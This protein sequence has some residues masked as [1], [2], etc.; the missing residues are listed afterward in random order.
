MPAGRGCSVM[1]LVPLRLSHL[2]ENSPRSF[3]G[4]A[5]RR[6][7][8]PEPQRTI[9][10]WLLD[11]GFAPSARPGMTMESFY[12]LLAERRS[13]HVSLYPDG[14]RRCI[15][16][17]WQYMRAGGDTYGMA[18]SSQTAQLT[19]AGPFGATWPV[20]YMPFLRVAAVIFAAVVFVVDTFFAIDIAIAVLYV[21]VVILSI[22][23][24]DRRGFMAVSAGCIGL[25][26]LAF[27][28][29]APR[30]AALQFRRALCCQPSG[31]CDHHLPVRLDPVVNRGGP[32]PGR[33]PRSDPR[34]DLRAR[35]E[36]RHHLLESGRGRSLRLAGKAG[37]GQ[38]FARA[39]EDGFS[40][41]LREDHGATVASRLL[42]RRP[43]SHQARRLARS[44]CRAAGRFS[45]TRAAVRLRRSRPTRTSRRNGARRKIWSRRRPSSRT[46]PAYRRSAS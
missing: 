22:T 4:A 2:D 38:G 23:F 8:N 16:P 17:C 34:C 45:A 15:R 27:A 13:R 24:C 43:R 44:R 41:A 28:D 10:D 5:K 39:G 12:N 19:E 42:G 36:R 11:S 1:R 29:P 20:A 30:R 26:V 40:R 18:R 31:D 21:A 32:Q 46:C 9:S 25:T 7:R 3:R 35:H 6:T 14:Q 33:A 37:L